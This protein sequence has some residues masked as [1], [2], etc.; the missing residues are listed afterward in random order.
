MPSLP[1][2][3]PKVGDV[4]SKSK[5]QLYLGL[6]RPK[7]LLSGASSVLVAIFYAWAT[8]PQ[9]DFLKVGLLLLVAVTA[10]MAS[11]IVNDL[12]D[13]Q[14]GADTTERQGPLRPL[15]HGLLSVGDVRRALYLVLA[16]LIAAG[17][18]LLALSSWWLSLV[19]LGVVLGLFAYSGG[20][21]PLAYHGLGDVAVL[22][23]F[24]LVPVV[25]SYYILGGSIA[26]PTIWHLAT[27]IGLSSVNILVV[28]N[29]RDAAEDH[30]AGKRTLIVRMGRD[31]A[32]RFYL[33]CGLLSMGLLY[34]IFSFWG[35][36]CLLPY[37]ILF[38][39]THRELQQSEGRA[40]NQVL[41]H[42]ARNVFLLALLI[43]LMLL[44]HPQ[45]L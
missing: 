26:D 38:S 43:G 11:N 14:R 33:T 29:Y 34:P 44:L 3:A 45:F 4:P 22:V 15:T 7:T 30:K 20:P 24:G 39:A 1:T 16:L 5:L 21:Y 12:Q 13:H 25:T 17:I 19:G 28:N 8:L 42:T 6:L 2:E 31:F 36:L 37:V 40:L 32:P 27:T 41:A 10:Q 18:S 23:F 9:L 35:M